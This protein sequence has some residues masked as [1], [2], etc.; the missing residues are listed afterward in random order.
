[1]KIKGK[2]VAMLLGEK[3]EVRTRKTD[4]QMYTFSTVAIM[5]NGEVDNVRVET[6]LAKALPNMEHFKKYEMAFEFDTTY[7]NMLVV[8]MRLFEK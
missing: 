4:N 7:N 1:M 3:S 8:D 5:Q 6:E 2:F